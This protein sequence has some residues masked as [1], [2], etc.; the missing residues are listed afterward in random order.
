MLA[1]R[2]THWRK[3][4]RA[5]DDP[6]A[7]SS[8]DDLVRCEGAVVYF[9][10]DVSKATVLKL[11]SCLRKA[12]AHA[13]CHAHDLQQPE[14]LLYIHSDGGDA[15]AGLSAYGHIVR[16]RVPVATVMDGI[17]ASAASFLLLA[18]HKRYA[19]RQSY[20]LIHQLSTGF[21]GKY[22]DMVDEVR[23]STSLMDTFRELYRERT[24]LGPKRLEALLKKERTLSAATC[25]KDG[26]VHEVL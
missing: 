14:V 17:V 19:T 9:H 18:G 1:Q 26:F 2:T 3:R 23:N 5:D 21:C 11:V 13:L 22:A 12:T 16:N 20:L 10:A 8:E 6:D 4:P 24:T 7:D 25:L 15:Y